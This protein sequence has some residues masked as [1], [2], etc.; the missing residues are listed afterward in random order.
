[1]KERKH[2][3]VGRSSRLRTHRQLRCFDPDF[4]AS[5]SRDWVHN[6][7]QR[8]FMVLRVGSGIRAMRVYRITKS[9][10]Y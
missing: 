8:I 5:K 3:E 9:V 6:R 10:L 2:A 4:V 1:M 7:T